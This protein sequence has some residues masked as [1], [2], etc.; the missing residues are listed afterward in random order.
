LDTIAGAKNVAAQV[1]A[2]GYATPGPAADDAVYSLRFGLALT[3]EGLPALN[4]A[5]KPSKQ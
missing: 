1:N 4:A 5:K 3:R 2:S